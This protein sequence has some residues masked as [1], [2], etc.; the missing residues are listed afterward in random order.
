VAEGWI[1]SDSFLQSASAQENFRC[2]A[3]GFD[4][5]S[6]SYFVEVV[7]SKTAAAGRAQVGSVR[8]EPTACFVSP[9]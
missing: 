8:L 9:P 3:H 7:L 5:G 1:D 4:F 2:I 6:N